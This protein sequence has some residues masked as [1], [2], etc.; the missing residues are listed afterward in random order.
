M[1]LLQRFYE[2][3]NALSKYVVAV[4]ASTA[5]SVCD[6]QNEN[7]NAKDLLDLLDFWRHYCRLTSVW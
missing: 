2:Q 1:D 6:T 7:A 5:T 4:E 3:A